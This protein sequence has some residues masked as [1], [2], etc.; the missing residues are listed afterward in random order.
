MFKLVEKGL[1]LEE[2]I[3]KK[4]EIESNL[5]GETY[6]GQKENERVVDDIRC[7]IC[8]AENDETAELW[9]TENYDETSN[10]TY[11]IYE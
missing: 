4:E 11:D 7:A 9:Y 6:W 8:Y 2:F 1:S 10:V 3:S 5:E